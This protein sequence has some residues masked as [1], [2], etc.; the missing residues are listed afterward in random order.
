MFKFFTY[1]IYKTEMFIKLQ[2]SIWTK[3]VKEL[4]VYFYT[5]VHNITNRCLVGTSVTSLI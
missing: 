5:L 1:I 4:S 2:I 3:I